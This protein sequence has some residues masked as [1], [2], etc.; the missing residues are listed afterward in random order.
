MPLN[1]RDLRRKVAGDLRDI[2]VVTAHEGSST[3]MIVDPVELSYFDNTLVS[4]QLLCSRSVNAANV[5]HVARVTGS[6]QT[7]KNIS[8]D[9]PTPQPV[10]PGDEFELVNLRGT[11]FRLQDYTLQINSYVQQEAHRYPRK[12]SSELMTFNALDPDL[13]IPEG[14]IAIY[15]VTVVLPGGIWGKIKPTRAL[16]ARGWWADPSSMSVVIGGS[17]AA[18]CDGQQI[19]LDGLE[20]HPLLEDD[21][22]PCYMDAEHLELT[23][24]SKLAQRRGGNE[25]SQWAIEWSRNAAGIR[26][27]KL[28][29]YPANTVMLERQ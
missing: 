25:W 19:L 7:G 24:A 1:R 20:S 13:P 8:F 3:N 18:L 29:R 5:G 15:G 22:S 21:D 9:P 27:A 10:S 17:D 2:M 28:F 4:S 16:G 23:V 14:W 11:G 12:V 26:P 6:S